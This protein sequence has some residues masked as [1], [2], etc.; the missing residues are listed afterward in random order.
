MQHLI[1]HQ[2]CPP[3]PLLVTPCTS[4]PPPPWWP[5]ASSSPSKPSQNRRMPPHLRQQPRRCHTPTPA[6]PYRLLR[7][8]A[9]NLRAGHTASTRF[10]DSH[11]LVTRLVINL[12]AS[13]CSVI[14]LAPPPLRGLAPPPAALRPPPRAG[15][16][17]RPLPP[18]LPLRSARG[19]SSAR[20]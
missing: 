20:Q 12:P 8:R 6:R 3:L 15:N 14:W 4:L 11:R 17:P 10:V 13:S 19:T 7:L 18:A 1:T 16:P 9:P 5:R 2:Q